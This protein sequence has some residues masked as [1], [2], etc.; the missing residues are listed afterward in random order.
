MI[1]ANGNPHEDARHSRPN[2]LAL[3]ESAATFHYGLQS[4]M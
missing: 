1:L 2:R 4:R 3:Q